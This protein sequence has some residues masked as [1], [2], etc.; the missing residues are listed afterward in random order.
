MPV[1]PR[2]RQAAARP[3]VLCGQAF[4]LHELEFIRDSAARCGLCMNVLLDQ[5]L[6][7]AEFEELVVI[8]PIGRP[9]RAATLWRTA[10][11]IVAQTAGGPPKAFATIR[12]ATDHALANLPGSA[13]PRRRFSWRD[14]RARALSL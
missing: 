8:R 1:T 14:L 5:V 10:H 3:R 13:P 12:A 4:P 2:H 7:G 9:H 11:S 6:D